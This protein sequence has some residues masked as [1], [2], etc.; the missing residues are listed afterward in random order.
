MEYRR[1]SNLKHQEGENESMSP[2]PQQNLKEQNSP[3][4]EITEL[5][6]LVNTILRRAHPIEDK[7]DLELFLTNVLLFVQRVEGLPLSEREKQY[8]PHSQF[9]HTTLSRG[10]Q[11]AQGLKKR[12][13][14]INRYKIKDAQRII[15]IVASTAL[16][17]PKT[18]LTQRQIKIILELYQEPLLRQYELA[19]KLSTT[20]QIVKQEL[21]ELRRHFSLAVIHDIDY[22]K[23]KLALVEIQ[24]RTKSIDASEGLEQFYRRTPPLFLHQIRFDHDYRIGF[25]TYMIPDQPRGYRFLEDRIKWLKD[26]FLEEYIKFRLKGEAVSVS[27][28]GYDSSNGV[29]ML[30]TDTIAEMMLQHAQHRTQ[31]L[32]QPR[33]FFYSEP[34]PFDQI[35]YI[36][37]QTPYIFG[38]KKRI[39]VRQRVLERHGYTLSKTGIW[40]REQKLRKAG[41]YFPTIWFN[42]PELEELV[43]FS[44]QCSSKA[45]ERIFRIASILPYTYNIIT[46]IGLVFVFQRPSRCS[47]ITGLLTR[48]IALEEGVSEVTLLRY[49]P[50]FSPQMLTHTASRWD[51]SRQRWLLQ[52][53][54]I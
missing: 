39:E 51:S 38:R 32:T 27:F 52:K 45:R 12:L 22:Q 46:D 50:S 34:M 33:G 8:P 11:T 48:L 25:I 41:V 5:K 30:G 13:M 14:I 53:G 20:P 4:D 7:K 47:L 26:E 2:D 23:F 42:I 15:S 18:R 24:F 9:F 44:V 36:L 21:E 29:W 49:E 40:N 3:Q 16:A 6:Q 1:R 31:S 35:D 10:R 54:D 37:A 28:D 43:Q 17:T 19:N